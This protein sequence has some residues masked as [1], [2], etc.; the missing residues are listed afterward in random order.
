MARNN[1]FLEIRKAQE[2]RKKSKYK[3]KFKG[4]KRYTDEKPKEVWENLKND[5]K[6]EAWQ[7]MRKTR[8]PCSACGTVMEYLS[9]GEYRCPKCGREELDEYGKVRRYVDEHGPTPAHIIAEETG[10]DREKIDVFL[11]KGKLEIVSGPEGYLKCEMCGVPIRFGRICQDCAR[12]EGAKVKGY[13][14]EEV[15]D[16]VHAEMRFKKKGGNA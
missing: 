2:Q 12:T 3:P 6:A 9:L 11:R 16:G 7:Y 8:R 14:L 15:G 13:F 5:T 1:V 4:V 10:V